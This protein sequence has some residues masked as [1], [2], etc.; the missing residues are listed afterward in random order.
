[1]NNIINE[2]ETFG[3]EIEA[4]I[5]LDDDGD[6]RRRSELAEYII[7]TT[8]VEILSE[9][10]NTETKSYWKIIHDGSVNGRGI[11]C[12]V[13]SPPLKGEK[14]MEQVKSIVDSMSEFGMEVN[15]STGL[16]VHHDAKN[17]SSREL[18]LLVQFY[19]FYEG[20]IDTFQPKSRR[21]TS[22]CYCRPVKQFYSADTAKLVFDIIKSRMEKISAGVERIGDTYNRGIKNT[23]MDT[24]FYNEFRSER[25]CKLNLNSFWKH[26]TVEFRHHSGTVDSEKILNWI[27]L[28]QHIL[29]YCKKAKSRITAKHSPSFHKMMDLLCVRNE[30]REFYDNRRKHF[31]KEYGKMDAGC[32]HHKSGYKRG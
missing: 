11:D 25:Y 1:M 3:V 21:G 2:Q 15:A 27:E 32:T 24:L 8:G 13:I 23:N 29:N 17:I 6:V 16:H 30:L 7:D 31:K 22:A 26:G 20:I 12:E 28:T 18:G 10:W 4:I 14:G 9:Q 19:S 5:N